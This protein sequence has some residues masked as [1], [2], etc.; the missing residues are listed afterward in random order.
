MAFLVDFFLAFS[1]GGQVIRCELKVIFGRSARRK[2]IE[3]VE[4][5]EEMLGERLEKRCSRGELR[6][7]HGQFGESRVVWLAGNTLTKK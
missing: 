5:F 1:G 3:G 4:L 7:G 6:R 2:P